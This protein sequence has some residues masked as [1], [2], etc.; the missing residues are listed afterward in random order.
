ME[1][2]ERDGK[3]MGEGGEGEGKGRR[4][5]RGGYCFVAVH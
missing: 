3:E 1:M 5:T 4:G 2:T